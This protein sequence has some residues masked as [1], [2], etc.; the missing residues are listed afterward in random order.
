[1]TEKVGFHPIAP[2]PVLAQIVKRWKSP[3]EDDK[4]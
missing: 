4:E 1:M 3:V 2:L